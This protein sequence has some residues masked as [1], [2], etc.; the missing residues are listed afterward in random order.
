VMNVDVEY[1][2]PRDRTS[3]ARLKLFVFV[4]AGLVVV[5]D[6]GSSLNELGITGTGGGCTGGDRTGGGSLKAGLDDLEILLSADIGAVADR[7]AFP[8]LSDGMVPASNPASGREVDLV[9]ARF[10]DGPTG[11]DPAGSLAFTPLDGRLATSIRPSWIVRFPWCSE[12]SRRYSARSAQPP[13][14]RTI[15]RSPFSPTRRT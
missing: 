15:T 4:V 5:S 2:G 3:V 13:P 9:F 8:I 7:R 12:Y 14:T 10:K 11:D 6:R 1:D